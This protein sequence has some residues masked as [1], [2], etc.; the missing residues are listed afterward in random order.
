MV[1]KEVG[2]T[3]NYFYRKAFQFRCLEEVD[4]VAR[5]AGKKA[6]HKVVK[7]NVAIKQTDRNA[8]NVMMNVENNNQTNRKNHNTSGDKRN[9]N[10]KS[11][12]GTLTRK[13]TF[14]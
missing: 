3:M 1:N 11:V 14:C 2:S 9:K 6:L 13:I 4:Y 8:C 10:N 5:M 12:Q 7:T